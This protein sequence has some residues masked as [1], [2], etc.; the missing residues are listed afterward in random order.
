MHFPS[1]LPRELALGAYKVAQWS[2]W[3]FHIIW[4]HLNNGLIEVWK[5]NKQVISHQGPNCFNDNLGP[6]FKIGL[7]K[8]WK[9][10]SNQ[11]KVSQRT[12]YFDDITITK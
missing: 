4:S 7:Y 6:Y 8:G 5:D 9:N 3:K 11:S 12:L 2:T 1:R 10:N